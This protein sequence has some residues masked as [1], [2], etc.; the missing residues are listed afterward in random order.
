MR[1]TE[2]KNSIGEASSSGVLFQHEAEPVRRR[3]V[4]SALA[5]TLGL[6]LCVYKPFGIGTSLYQDQ[7]A[8]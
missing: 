8:A 6:E 2:R 5:S 3:A 7:D 1:G 4:E